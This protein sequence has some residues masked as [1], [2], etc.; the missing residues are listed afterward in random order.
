[1]GIRFTRFNEWSH[2][3]GITNHR[4]VALGAH[5]CKELVSRFSSPQSFG[6]LRFGD[7]G[8]ESIECEYPSKQRT[9]R[10]CGVASNICVSLENNQS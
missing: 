10:D 9:E 1:M 7:E 6:F 3:P 4:A 5:V 8:S 2:H